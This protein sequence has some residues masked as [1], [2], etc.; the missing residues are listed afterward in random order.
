LTLNYE[1]GFESNDF[2]QLQPNEVVR[3]GSKQTGLGD[4][5]QGKY[6]QCIFFFFFRNGA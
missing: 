1:V 6:I 3:A 5:W 2:F 4:V